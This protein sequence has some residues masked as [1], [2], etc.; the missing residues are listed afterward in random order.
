MK[1]DDYAQQLHCFQFNYDLGTQLNGGHF[2]NISLGVHRSSNKDVIITTLFKKP[3]NVPEEVKILQRLTD[4]SGIVQLIDHYHVAPDTHYL[5]L[6]Y[7]ASM[8][9]RAYLAAF[10]RLSEGQAQKIMKQIISIVQNCS[11]KNILHKSIK[12]NNILINRKTFQIK[13]TNFG[14]ACVINSEL[15]TSKVW[16]GV[17]PPE[18]FFHKAYTADGLNVWTLG[19]LLYK[20]LFHKNPFETI[21]DIMFTPCY[22]SNICCVSPYVKH[23]I[24]QTLEKNPEERICLY[25]MEKHPWMTELL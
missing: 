8:T 13:L 18:F 23:L 24:F 19:M 20:T 16:Y 15:L 5:V 7:F 1:F 6:D 14:S 12:P 17:A 25:D 4:L 10:G 2:T 3:V 9:L 21:Y 11:M 22:I